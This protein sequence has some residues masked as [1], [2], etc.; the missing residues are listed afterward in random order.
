MDVRWL[1]CDDAY[2]TH[3]LRIVI[4]SIIISVIIPRAELFLVH[5]VGTKYVAEQVKRPLVSIGV[6]KPTWADSS[7]N[8]EKSVNLLRTIQLLATWDRGIRECWF[9]ADIRRFSFEKLE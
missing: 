1:I 6:R 7:T 9:T 8:S 3:D 5:T 2:F 4:L